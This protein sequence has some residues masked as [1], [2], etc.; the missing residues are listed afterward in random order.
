M[1]E[2]I[3][4]RKEIPCHSTNEAREMA[5]AEESADKPLH[6]MNTAAE[7]TLSFLKTETQI[8]ET[9]QM[10]RVVQSEPKMEIDGAK[11]QT[12]GIVVWALMHVPSKECNLSLLSEGRTP[13]HGMPV[14]A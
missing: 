3:V 6:L 7:F 5:K 11:H 13:S 12:A 4:S 9:N 1:L 14:K 2:R 8:R 10:Q